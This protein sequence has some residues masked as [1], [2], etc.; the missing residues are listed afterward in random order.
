MPSNTRSGLG[1]RELEKNGRGEIEKATE[2][3]FRKPNWDM[4]HPCFWAR[5]FSAFCD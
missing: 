1:F 2:R 4:F 5:A 3:F